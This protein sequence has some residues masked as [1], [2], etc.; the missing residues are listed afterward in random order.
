MNLEAKFKVCVCERERGG[1]FSQSVLIPLPFLG[2]LTCSKTANMAKL[3]LL[4]A[5]GIWLL[6]WA[7]ASGGDPSPAFSHGMMAPA[8]APSACVFQAGR[9]AKPALGVNLEKFTLTLGSTSG[10]AEGQLQTASTLWSF[11]SPK[12]VPHTLQANTCLYRCLVNV[13]NPRTQSWVDLNVQATELNF[14][15]YHLENSKSGRVCYVWHCSRKK[16]YFK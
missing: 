13:Q 4:G 10:S 12:E 16:L 14:S 15:G 5:G 2:L 8:S 7:L 1:L 11:P 3:G 6:S 9:P